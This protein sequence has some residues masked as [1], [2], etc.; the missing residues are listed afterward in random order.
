MCETCG[1]VDC[2]DEIVA[3]IANDERCACVVENL[4][5][6]EEGWG[7]GYFECGVSEPTA[8][9]EA[10]ALCW[11]ESCAQFCLAP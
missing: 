4:T 8:A 11:S 9:M 2:C 7:P 5:Q 1:K 3:C 10:L 6:V